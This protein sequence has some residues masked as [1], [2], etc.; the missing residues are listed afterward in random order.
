MTKNKLYYPIAGTYS[1][2]DAE[3]AYTQIL[4][5]S[6]NGQVYNVLYPGNEG[7]LG[8]LYVTYLESQGRI[9]FDSTMPFLEGETVNIIFDI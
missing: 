7:I 8:G 6:R 4:L 1:I 9:N 3:L 5:V 2:V